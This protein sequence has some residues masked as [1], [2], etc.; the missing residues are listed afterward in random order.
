MR[1]AEGDLAFVW[2]A[3]VALRRALAFVAEATRETFG[4][5]TEKRSARTSSQIL[6]SPGPG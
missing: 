5:D 1:P 2:D 3:C 4:G 6:A